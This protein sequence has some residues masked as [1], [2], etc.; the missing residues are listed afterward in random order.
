M[1]LPHALKV[2]D[3][4][5]AARKAWPVRAVLEGERVDFCRSS[6]LI[7]FIHS[8]FVGSPIDHFQL[9]FSSASVSC[10]VEEVHQS[11]AVRM[12]WLNQRQLVWQ[13]WGQRAKPKRRKWAQVSTDYCS[14]KEWKLLLWK[15]RGNSLCSETWK[16]MGGFDIKFIEI[17]DF[18]QIETEE[19]WQKTQREQMWVLWL[20]IEWESVVA[21]Q[22]KWS[23]V[24]SGESGR[25]V[26]DISPFLTEMQVNGM[27][28]FGVACWDSWFWSPFV[29]LDL[30]STKSQWPIRC[31]IEIYELPKSSDTVSEDFVPLRMIPGTLSPFPSG[32]GPIGVTLS[33]ELEKN[34]FSVFQYLSSNLITCLKSFFF[35]KGNWKRWSE[36]TG[37]FL[38]VK[39]NSSLAN[40]SP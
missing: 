35:L 11:N 22:R 33:D 7:Q 3:T 9:L 38:T 6:V 27:T 15:W 10:C 40:A 1:H 29:S 5:P 28:R 23:G 37:A 25:K 8:C 16:K 14:N 21:D 17:C 26:C 13:L 36:L 39:R 24:T 20:E 4:I 18:S 34:P 2:P 30:A 12:C 31:W 32:L 19:Y